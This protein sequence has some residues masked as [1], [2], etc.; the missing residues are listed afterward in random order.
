M[1]VELERERER[2]IHLKCGL[3][4]I[5]APSHSVRDGCLSGAGP[6]MFIMT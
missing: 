3:L 2:E 1:Q 4:N 6:I 5:N